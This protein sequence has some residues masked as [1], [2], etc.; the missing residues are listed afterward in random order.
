MSVGEK[1]E[2][3]IGEVAKEISNAFGYDDIVF[4]TSFSDGQYKK[5]ADNGKLMK[6][7]GDY[8]FMKISDGVKKSVDWFIGNF[9]R[10]RK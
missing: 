7:Y 4:D 2:T 3:S 8:E 1:D 6:L 10:C 9:E 5:T